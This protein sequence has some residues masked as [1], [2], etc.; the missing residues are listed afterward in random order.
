MRAD[1]TA[2]VLAVRL[3]GGV[4]RCAELDDSRNPRGTSADVVRVLH[5]AD[6]VNRHDFIDNIV[7]NVNPE[8][9][10]MA[11]CTMGR[12]SNIEDPRYQETDIPCWDLSTPTRRHYGLTA[13]RLAALLRRER[14]D[15][16]HAHHYEPCLI[17]AVATVLRPSTRL[18][19]G[20]HYS[21]AIY[22]HTHGVRRAVML[23]IEHLVNG[24]AHQVI[25]PSRR[26]AE[27]LIDRQGV[28]PERVAVIP[29][30]FDPAKYERVQT[31]TVKNLLRSLQLDGRFTI[32]TFGR[33]Y[34]DKGHR[35]VLDA[36][37]RILEFVPTLKY[38][39]VGEGAER[40]GL[41]RQVC[42]LGLE[43]AVVFLGWRH[44]VPELMAVVDAVVQPS[45]QEAFSQS[46]AEALLMGRPLV[47]TDVSGASEL[48]PHD[49]I[50]VVVPCRDSGALAHAII[51][52]AKNPPRR[53]A[54]AD[55]ARSHAQRS[56]TIE[57]AVTLHEGVYRD[58]MRPA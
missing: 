35:F 16:V 7:R 12:P 22:L 23:G 33:L 47:I 20:R 25:A 49:G 31:H 27:L 1:H 37:P 36:L 29:Y 15:I 53:A 44:D 42:A 19:V 28:P 51:E 18:V 57:A 30:G 54:L 8:G 11:V 2:P 52:L 48:V 21:D 32:A 46:M 40:E 45:L 50:G 34:E 3:A 9:F 56:F 6:L 4:L 5:F 24:R 26:I 38:L 39:I 10:R 13:L 43:E 55:A 41:K 17:A 14:I 58:S